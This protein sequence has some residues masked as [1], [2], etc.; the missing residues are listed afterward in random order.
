MFFNVEK[1]GFP[2]LKFSV[3]IFGFCLLL[4]RFFVGKDCRKKFSSS[5]MCQNNRK[6]HIVWSRVH[7]PKTDTKSRRKKQQGKHGTQRSAHAKWY[8]CFDMPWRH[9]F[10]LYRVFP[11]TSIHRIQRLWAWK[12]GSRELICYSLINWHKNAIATEMFELYF[13]VYAHCFPTSHMTNKL[14]S[15]F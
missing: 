6:Y 10:K 9:K 15:K 11:F 8:A 1:N 12:L 2:S 14:G 7:N 4:P 3:P 13:V 5:R